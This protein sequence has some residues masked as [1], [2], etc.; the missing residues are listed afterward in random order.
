[1]NKFDIF[2]DS[3]ADLTDEMIEANGITVIPYSYII[4]GVERPCYEKGVPFEETA[5]RFYDEMRAGK[6]PTTSLVNCEKIV[7]AVTPSMQEGR[8]ALI[9]TISSQISGTYAQA[10]AAAEELKKAFPERKLY[11]CDGYNSGLGEGMLAIQAAKLRDLGESAESCAEWVNTHNVNMNSIFTVS[12]LKYL[13]RGGRIS[14]TLAIAGT[15]LN[16]KPILRADG[17]GKI[18]FAGNERGRRKALAR[19]VDTF[20]ENVIDPE[21]QT[22]AISHADCIDDANTLAEMLKE[23]GAKD[24]VINMLDICSGVHAGPGMLAL[25]F[26]GKSRKKDAEPAPAV[27]KNVFGAKP[28]KQI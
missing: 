3:S 1:M 10:Q 22:I 26:M 17:N 21:N 15:I 5:K 27:K 4:D 25:F 12:E 2:V 19:L 28:K 18:V 16:I 20:A 8:D 7:A 24:I 14:T 6:E 11:V 23:R 13:K 9:V